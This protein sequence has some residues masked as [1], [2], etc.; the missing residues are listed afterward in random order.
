MAL[1]SSSVSATFAAFGM[2]V[3]LGANPSL[4]APALHF[5]RTAVDGMYAQHNT[6]NTNRQLVILTNVGTDS[7]TLD[8][9]SPQD[10]GWGLYGDCVGGL[11]LGPG[12]RCQLIVE[13]QQGS[14][15]TSAINIFSNAPGSPHAI[16]VSGY[17]L[18]FITA[19][20]LFPKFN[21][22]WADFGVQPPGVLSGLLQM[23]LV[24]TGTGPSVNIAA[25]TIGGQHPGDFAVSGSCTVGSSLPR[26]GSCTFDVQF[27]AG[28]AGPRSAEIYVKEASLGA[29]L[30]LALA[31]HGSGA[32][33][34]IAQAIEFY[35][36]ALD[37]Y[38][39]THIAAEIAILD[40]GVQIKGWARTGETITV[41]VAA[42]GATSP[43]CRF[44]IPPT[45]GDSH[46]Y[47]RGTSECAS[48]GQRNP[49][50]VNEDPQFFHMILPVAG[51]CSTGTT[52]VF[53]A[54]SNRS[55]ANH[56]YM[57]KT[58]IRDQMIARNWLAEGDGPD[59]VVMCAPT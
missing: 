49:S 3:L 48:T 22:A 21:P 53:R 13:F 1:L 25:I 40:A 55:D 43:V 35:N 51:V 38:F 9:L 33:R 42:D 54:F 46:F 41:A 45:L 19:P 39:L 20:Q 34:P 17:I 23:T 44:Y 58:A 7:L 56:R 15:F 12:E 14:R 31:G 24:N 30:P 36:L 10:T 5:S 6:S 52:K 28:G 8:F 27:V 37:H 4:A 18:T 59:L 57:T 50:F 11:H 16:A 32:M 29:Q 26:N 47:G 2:F